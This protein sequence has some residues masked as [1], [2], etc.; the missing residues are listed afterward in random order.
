MKHTISLL[1]FQMDFLTAKEK[2]VWFCA[3][4]GTGK[5][6]SLAQYAIYRLLT[7]PETLGL[8]AAAT[9][10]QLRDA[11]LVEL[12]RELDKLGLKYSYSTL[13]NFVTLDVNGARLKAFSMENY[14][15]LRGLEIGWF[16]LDE[17]T[18]VK[19]EAYNVLL[20][21]LRCKFSARLE[22]RCTS[23][24]RGYD[25]MHARYVGERKNAEHRLIHATSY[26]NPFLP[27]GYID[28]MVAGYDSKKIRQ[29]VLAEFVST[30]E[31]NVYH[32]FD[33]HE[34]IRATPQL[35]GATIYVGMD[36]NV[37]PMTAVLANVAHGGIR[38]FDEVYLKHS[39]TFAMAQEIR[40]RYPHDRI[41]VVPDATGSSRKTSSSQSD[42]QI[43][44]AA[45][46]EVQTTRRNPAVEDRFNTVNGRLT[47]GLIQIDP[48]CAML[49]RDLE[50][51]THEHNP[52]YLTHISDAFGYLAWRI[53]P[54][55]RARPASRVR[56]L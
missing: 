36:F 22:G 6:Y 25:H 46:F 44:T 42:H 20:G 14:E 23:T 35:E 13:T 9:Y 33:R 12:F 40:K 39:N 50:R 43:L 52:D 8:L 53:F 55:K 19:E 29:E 1:P 26:D 56:Q 48:K 49:V 15:M 17:A 5:T 30:A 27:A 21:R 31:G 28:S 54:V 41:V 24:P 3:G 2:F 32:A 4:L 47:Q 16:G 51:V 37:N 18:L 34:H 38:A 45:G 7:N 10:G 11:T